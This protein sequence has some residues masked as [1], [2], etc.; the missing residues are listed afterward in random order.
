MGQFNMM[1][2][3]ANLQALYF[4]G[5]LETA[6]A[7]VGQ[8]CGRIDAIKTVKEV[9]DETIAGFERVM[10]QLASQYS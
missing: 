1:E 10:K 5:D 8:V 6:I 9:V 3:M 7:L 4:G 2:P